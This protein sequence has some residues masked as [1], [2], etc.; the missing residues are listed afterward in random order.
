MCYFTLVD[1][2]LLAALSPIVSYY[3]VTSY[4]FRSCRDRDLIRMR[5]PV[6]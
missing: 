4:L 6:L 5:G 3:F 1:V 2:P